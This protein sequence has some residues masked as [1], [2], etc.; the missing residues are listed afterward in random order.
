MSILVWFVDSYL[1][2]DQTETL[3]FQANVD[4]IGGKKE[5]EQVM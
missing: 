4:K 1:S 2:L 3:E 5:K